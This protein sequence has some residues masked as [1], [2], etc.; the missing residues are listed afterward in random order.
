ML[1]AY[2]FGNPEFVPSALLV[3]LL[4]AFG[5][6]EPAA[7]AAL[8]RLTRRGDLEVARSGRHTAYRLAPAELRGRP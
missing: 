8:S 6:G 3:A 2:W 1:L 4:G 7:R 5:V